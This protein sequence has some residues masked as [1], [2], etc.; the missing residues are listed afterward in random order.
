[1]T[2]KKNHFLPWCVVAPTALFVA[3]I[4]AWQYT[5]GGVVSHHF[6]DRGDMP[7]VSNWWGLIVLPGLGWLASWFAGRRAAVDP[8][9][10]PQAFAAALGAALVG[11]AMSLTFMTGHGQATGYLF[12]A[13]LASGLVLPTYRAEYV[14]GFGLGMV[15]VFG[16]VLPTIVALIGVAIS[17]IAHFLI[18]PAFG[19]IIRRAGT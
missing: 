6:L 14:F 16:M 15:F 7:V 13:A 10:L 9:A 2:R 19:R 12:F 3:A 1:M 8:K 5:H 4:L 18:R 11:V 17:A